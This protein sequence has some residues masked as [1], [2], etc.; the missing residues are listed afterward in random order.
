[1]SNFLNERSFFGHRSSV[2]GNSR[3]SSLLGSRQ[4]NYSGNN[5]GK[6]NQGRY[7]K[8]D[9]FSSLFGP[10][11]GSS[12]SQNRNRSSSGYHSSTIFG[13][14]S[15]RD[16][17]N[18]NYSLSKHY[19]GGSENDYQPHFEKDSR[20]S[21]R[22]DVYLQSICAM[23]K[24]SK[25]S[26]EELRL[27]DIT[28]HFTG[29]L[30]S[31]LNSSSVNRSSNSLFSRN[32]SGSGNNGG[33][34][35]FRNSSSG[36]IFGSGSGRSNRNSN[37]LF[38][39]RNN[40][41]SNRIFGNNYNNNN[42]SSRSNSL[43]GNSGSGLFSRS[44]NNNGRRSN[45]LFGNSNRNSNSL[46]GNRNNNSSNSIFG[47]NYNN[48]NRSNSLFGN[49]GS[50]LFSRSNNSGRRSN[51]LFGNSNRNSN[52][53]FGN[54]NR[55]N[56]SIF[57]NRSNS[58]ISLFGNRSNGSN[59]IFSNKNGLFNKGS[60]LFSS[61]SRNDSQGNSNYDQSY[62]N[63]IQLVE[64]S[65]E[66]PY[67]YSL[68]PLKDPIQSNYLLDPVSRFKKSSNPNYTKKIAKTLTSD[69]KSQRGQVKDENFFSNN[70]R[71]TEQ[72]SNTS[73]NDD[74]NVA[75][76][77][78]EKISSEDQEII[79]SVPIQIPVKV[80]QFKVT[81]KSPL[82]SKIKPR[83]YETP[84]TLFI[85]LYKNKPKL[86]SQINSPPT[87]RS[88]GIKKIIINDFSLDSKNKNSLHFKTPT[89]PKRNRRSYSVPKKNSKKKITFNSLDLN[90]YN[91]NYPSDQPQHNPL[92]KNKNKNEN[93]NENRDENKNEN[94]KNKKK[95]QKTPKKTKNN[96]NTKSNEITIKVNPS[97][98]RIPN[99][100]N[101]N[102]QT[103]RHTSNISSPKLKKKIARRLDFE[104]NNPK[105]FQKNAP[106][107]FTKKDYYT[108]PSAKKLLLMN[109]DQLT[110]IKDLI[111]GR[112]GYGEV[113]FPG[114]T[115]IVDLHLE[116][117]IIFNQ[118]QIIVYPDVSKR[119][120][121]GKGLNKPAKIILKNCFPLKKK[122]KE[123]SKNPEKIKNLI[124]KL[125]I[126]TTKF[127]G[128]F[129]TWS[130]GKW[131]F[132]VQDFSNN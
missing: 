49:S 42:N 58:S 87:P 99:K 81:V 60:S 123:P 33:N 68:S 27:D 2:Y 5:F 73:S 59:F 112:V 91:F 19:R 132:E 37:S 127:D 6:T 48:N 55:N 120:S 107:L 9:S 75:K 44:S 94:R 76:N 38:G 105:M 54:R 119:P 8:D 11:K 130:N 125:K 16:R 124:K 118:T 100:N 47:N 129:I 117:I 96:T 43:F 14:N 95:L 80:N 78:N 101:K 36:S 41:S 64:K 53:L 83:S 66:D 22:K 102:R 114:T 110:Q 111:I 70:K 79:K 116:E 92:T 26:P 126:A 46:F 113:M 85:D 63:I 69:K 93:R 17:T 52:S 104:S 77:N 122:S 7:S 39:N 15:T 115:N 98:K 106:Y 74:R 3:R 128:K 108:V 13:S 18:S 50:G 24:Y 97:S 86:N 82:K 62:D 12:Y 109:Y 88:V 20:R 61:N 31:Y 72:K 121:P 51:S 65:Y 56:N 131:V 67:G 34:S 30:P 90:N 1:M 4:S 89:R 35:L 10:R 32:R 40:N 45:S 25:K 103:R 84:K 57:G 21:N 71:N 23:D 29:S 28:L